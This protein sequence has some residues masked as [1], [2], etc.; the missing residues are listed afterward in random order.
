MNS[1]VLGSEVLTMTS[2]EI[3][4]LCEKR[5]DNV[6]ADCRKLA[7]FYAQTYSPEKSGEFVKS[8]TYTDST[9]R[10]LPCFE[11][12]KQACLDLVTGYSLPHRH[13]VNRRWQ[14]LEAAQH[15]AIPD[16]TNPAAAARAWALEYEAKEQAEERARIAIATKAQIGSS[17]EATCMATAS[18]AV[19]KANSLQ[20]QLDRAKDY[21]TVKR[22]QMLYHGQRFNWRLL[23]DA[24]AEMGIAPVDVFDANY[25]TVKAYHADVW[26]AAY[27]VGIDGAE[28][29]Q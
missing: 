17:R 9:G 6:M 22:M 11:L 15:K 10:G 29:V 3:A 18:A 16:F 14:E 2:R 13:A 19:R 1:I 7:D 28:V 8:A 27:A 5:H 26:M 25:G 20:R 23:R 4:E 21:A 12:N 24:S